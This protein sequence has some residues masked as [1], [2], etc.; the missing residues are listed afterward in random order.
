MWYRL[1]FGLVAGC[2]LLLS[3]AG[4]QVSIRDSSISLVM[5]SPFYSGYQ[6]GGDMAKRY[7]YTS[8]IGIECGYKHRNN[9]YASLSVGYLFGENLK[10]K[11]IFKDIVTASGLLINQYGNLTTV[12]AQERGLV[13]PLRVGKIWPFRFPGNNPNSGVY[14][15][16]GVQ[17]IEHYIHIITDRSIPMLSGYYLKGYDRL[18]AGTGFLGALGYRFFGNRRA[19]NF[20]AG[21][22]MSYNHTKSQRP[23]DF[24]LKQRNSQNRADILY[25]FRAGWALPLYKQAPEKQ[26]FF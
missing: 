19:V 18:T 10:E 14:T 11:T 25:G 7:G 4:A 23:Y 24:D 26:Y 22:E 16:V 8:V 6:P 5:V 17:F 12:G 21:F 13:V 9:F 2:F 3:K 20:F 1:L 15:E